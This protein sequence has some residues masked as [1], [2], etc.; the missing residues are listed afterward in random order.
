MKF[1]DAI[2]SALTAVR[3]NV[4]RSVLTALGIIIGV[5]AVIVMV[6]VGSGAQER[7]DTYIRGLG[8]NLLLVWPGS[9][10]VGGVK[11]GRVLGQWPGLSDGVLEGPGDLPVTTNYRNVLAPILQHHGANGGL[12][13]IFPEF[14]A[15]PLALY[16]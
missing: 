13:K 5:A 14:S 7:I 16:G 2:G 4:L 9:S 10:N 8:S 12:D 6:A 1:A 11:G 3:A 15:A